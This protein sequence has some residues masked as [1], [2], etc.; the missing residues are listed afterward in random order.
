MLEILPVAHNVT[1]NL[2][3]PSRPVSQ[4]RTIAPSSVQLAKF[5][6]PWPTD[7]PAQIIPH[8]FRVE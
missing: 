2:K 6:G 4:T 8:F 1:E 5:L 7:F 3:E